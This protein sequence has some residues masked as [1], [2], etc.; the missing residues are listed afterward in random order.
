M[1]NM[2]EESAAGGGIDPWGIGEG[3]PSREN[4]SREDE[5]KATRRTATKAETEKRCFCKWD[6]KTHMQEV[7]LSHVGTE[8]H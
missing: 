3:L 1:P 4:T 6:G 5:E 2:L 8:N 7:Y